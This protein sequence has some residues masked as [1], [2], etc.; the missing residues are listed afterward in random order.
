MHRVEW[1]GF[2]VRGWNAN[3]QDELLDASRTKTWHI[4]P[5]ILVRSQCQGESI[6]FNLNIQISIPELLGG[7][8]DEKITS[9]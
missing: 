8:M 9:E 1:H 7:K 6:E 3:C 2:E 4:P 5:G